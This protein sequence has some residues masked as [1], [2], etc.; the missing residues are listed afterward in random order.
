M[1]SSLI[2]LNSLSQDQYSSLNSQILRRTKNDSQPPPL[3]PS[4]PTNYWPLSYLRLPPHEIKMITSHIP[5][6][7]LSPFSSL[8]PHLLHLRTI[9]PIP[10]RTKSLSIPKFIIPLSITIII[11]CHNITLR[12]GIVLD[13]IW[14]HHEFMTAIMYRLGIDP[15]HSPSIPGSFKDGMIG[16]CA[17]STLEFI[18]LVFAIGSL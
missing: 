8:P 6:I 10:M 13:L 1:R 11:R 4:L 17:P 2:V 15:S 14:D 18:I 9:D 16:L 5:R 12:H 7:S 3:P